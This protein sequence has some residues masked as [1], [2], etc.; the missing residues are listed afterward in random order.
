MRGAAPEHDRF[1]RRVKSAQVLGVLER[2]QQ[3]RAVVLVTAL[4]KLVR[5]L[6]RTEARREAHDAARLFE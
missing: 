5:G 2:R 4:P 6:A 3:R 1:A